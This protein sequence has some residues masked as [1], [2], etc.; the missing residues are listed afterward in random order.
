MKRCHSAALHGSVRDTPTHLSCR[1]CLVSVVVMRVAVTL[2]RLTSRVRIPSPAPLHFVPF[3]VRRA[4]VFFGHA[5]GVPSVSTN[6][7]GVFALGCRRLAG[8]RFGVLRSR[9]VRS[10]CNHESVRRFRLGMPVVGRVA[11]RAP[12]VVRQ[13]PLEREVEVS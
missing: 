13:Q 11:L 6:R 3:C 7:L 10:L 8:S 9:L 4:S 2:P 5:F 12:L 1:Y